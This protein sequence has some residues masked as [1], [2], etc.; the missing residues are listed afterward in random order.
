MENPSTSTR[1]SR[2]T[3]DYDGLVRKLEELGLEI[4]ISREDYS[5]AKRSIKSLIAALLEKIQEAREGSRGEG[6][7]VR[8]TE[9]EIEYIIYR[10]RTIYGDARA[11]SIVAKLSDVLRSP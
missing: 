6:L 11:T 3:L 8:L 2:E 9:E 1:K 7:N 5:R 10:L 4:P